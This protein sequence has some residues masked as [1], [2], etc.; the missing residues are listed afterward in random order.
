MSSSIGVHHTMLKADTQPLA[1]RAEEMQRSFVRQTASSARNPM[2]RAMF[3]T[4][5]SHRRERATGRCHPRTPLF[6]AVLS[7][8]I[9]HPGWHF[10]LSRLRSERDRDPSEHGRGRP[11]FP[12][13]AV[14][15][16]GAWTLT[17]DERTSDQTSQSTYPQHIT[18]T[19]RRR[20][21]SITRARRTVKHC[22]ATSATV[23]AT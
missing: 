20:R 21:S 7:A 17:P 14:R 12:V 8:T 16:G 6:D 18:K 22:G 10:A 2:G 5:S 23:T 15:P 19:V 1:V 9:E 13:F 11:R 4:R 3:T